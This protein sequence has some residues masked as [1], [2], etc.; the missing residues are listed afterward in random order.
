MARLH[1]D[2]PERTYR[3]ALSIM[4]LVERLP[5]RTVGWVLGKQLLRSGTSVGANLREADAALTKREF[6]QFCNISRR[7][8]LESQYWLCLCRDRSLLDAAEAEKSIREADEIARILATIIC[9]SR[10]PQDAPS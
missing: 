5:E 4:V 9:R 8:A 3:F 1:G 2:L 10:D 6:V 7:E